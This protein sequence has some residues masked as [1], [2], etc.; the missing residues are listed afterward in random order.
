MGKVAIA[1]SFAGLDLYSSDGGPSASFDATTSTIFLRS[2]DGGL[3]PI[4]STN[5]GGSV[6]AG[7]SLGDSFYFAGS[8]SSVSGQNA[9]NIVSYNPSTSKFTA[10]AGGGLDGAVEAIYCDSSSKSVWAGGAFHG[11]SSGASGYS[12]SVAVYTP[13]SNSWA[14]PGFGGLSGPVMSIV[15]NTDSS[16]LLFG[17]SFLTSYQSGSTTPNNNVTSVSNPNVPQSSGSTPFSSSLVPFPLGGAEITAG[18]SSSRAGLGDI[19]AILCPSGEDG[20]G[21]TWFGREGSYN[22]IIIRNFQAMTARGIRLGNTFFDG[23][24]TSVFCVTSIPD[25]R[26]LTLRYNVP[27]SSETRTCSDECPLSTDPS[28]AFQDFVFEAD[29]ITG[30]LINLKEWAKDGV[31]LHLLQLLSDGS[32]ASAVSSDNASPCYAPGPSNAHATG[33]W[34]QATVN[35]DIPATVQT[36]LTSNVAVGSTTSPSV[37]WNVY[38]SASGQYEVYLIVPGCIN[39]QDCDS[40]TSV[41]VTI[42][43]GGSMSPITTTVSEQNP[44]DAEVLV[45]KGPLVP[46]TPDYTITVRLAL[47]ANPTGQGVGGQYTLVAGRVMMKLI[48]TDTS[49]NGTSTGGSNGTATSNSR[50][51]FGI[52]EWPL[53]NSPSNVNATGIIPNE[54][55]TSL[56]TAA[57]NLY[58]GLGNSTSSVSGARIE[59]IVPYTSDKT[60]L[61]GRF[62]L[63]DGTANIAQFTSGALSAL[64]NQ[65]LN[66]VVSSMVLYGSTLFV[67]GS[68]NSTA[69]NSVSL[70]N[71]AAYNVGSNQWSALGG[72]LDGPVSSLGLS[73]GHLSVV[74]NF[75]RTLITSST[76]LNAAGLASWNIAGGRWTNSGGLLVGKISSVFNATTS[77]D[78]KQYISGSI[79]M[80]LKYGADGAA[81]ISN[82]ES[83]QPAITPL[84]ARLDG[85]TVST[86]ERKRWLLSLRD[87]LAPRQSAGTPL[88]DDEAA[89]APSVLGGVF[90][91][92][93]TTSRQVMIIGGNFTVPGTTTTSLAIYDPSDESVVG[94]QGNQV[95]GVIRT[96]LIVGSKLFVG[97]EFTL[98][99]VQG[100]S[101]A[102][103]DLSS[104]LWDT[105]ISGLTA[106]SGQPV[107]RSITSISDSSTTVIVAGSFASAGGVQCNGI[108]AL[109]PNGRTWTALGSNAGGDIETVSYAGSNAEILL[110]AG[111]LNLAGSTVYIA[112]YTSQNQS[113]TPVGTLPGPVTALGVNDRNQSSLFAAGQTSSGAFVSHWDGSQWTSIDLPLSASSNITQLELVPLQEDH[114]SKSIIESNRMLWISGSLSG[115]NFTRASSALYD[116]QNLYPYL[117]T[118]SASGD[119]GSIS[120]F[121]HSFSTFDFNRRKFLAVGV[122]IL[123]S[124]ALGAGIVFLLGLIGILWALF[125]RRDDRSFGQDTVVEDDDSVRPSSLLAHVNAAARNTILG[126]P[127]ND[128]YVHK[129]EDTIVDDHARPSTAGSQPAA[130]AMAGGA[131]TA[132]GEHNALTPVTTTDEHDVNRPAHARYSFDGTGEGELP[133]TSGQQVVVLNDQDPTWWFVR[134]NATQR[135]GIVPSAY[136]A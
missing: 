29:S 1:G 18:P 117:V 37:T 135:E 121:F 131:V 80:Y 71:I 81:S 116:G 3:S 42:N 98:Q 64:A 90:W 57:F 40:R 123:I 104:Q 94:L 26:V 95:D 46:S 114:E 130:A 77:N 50:R 84:G 73:D 43:P 56:T 55:E 108:C 128:Y 113:W 8:F 111:S 47:A 49:S 27:G 97:G 53:R 2:A 110:A 5:A 32:F 30:V 89:P 20:P 99:G 112:A 133:L 100:Q 62:T 67:G 115:S 45:Y 39:M 122:V 124:I 25:N 74:G 127:K 126:T 15:S 91:T 85:S 65:G 96:L 59:S 22:T 70:R 9:A 60:F 28:V 87:I 134:D 129:G 105:G 66:G 14:P 35:T 79:S 44:Q 51:G 31:G 82:G 102:V 76:A 23:Q 63:R 109:D 86:S 13:S 7:C 52:Y 17:G 36:V 34:S 106:S 68:F 33:S 136:L 48:S 120:S 54:T 41:D 119:A 12:G 58:S 75:T 118:S 10:L 24:S 92:N 103:Y 107:V 61:G 69:D 83:G 132:A 88:P 21:S 38:T 78:N 93:T 72:G 11:P 16:S 101:F 6:V 125:S 4:G 19:N